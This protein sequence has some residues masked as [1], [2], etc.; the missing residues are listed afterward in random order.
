MKPILAFVLFYV[1]VA[2]GAYVF[3]RRLQYLPDT[4]LVEPWQAGLAGFERVA[5]PTADG[6]D[7]V[8]WYAPPAGGLP[9]II[10][11]QGNGLGI[12][13]RT[14]RFA[15]FHKDGYGVLALGYRGYS[16]SPGAPSE[17][18]LLA[19]AD[20]AVDF[21]EAKGFAPSRIVLY[22][23]SLGTGLAIPLAAR[24]RAGAV[25]LEAP[26]TS[27]L[28]IARRGW[29]FLPVGFLMKDQFHSLAAAGKVTVPAFVLH[30]TADEVVPFAH[31]EMIHAA[32]TGP[33]EFHPVPG[34]THGMPLTRP[35]WEAMKAF[36]RRQHGSSRI[37]AKTE[38]GA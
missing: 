7:L 28:A 36:L 25:I 17:E 19:D 20:A 2:G 16:G 10:Y 31:G 3:Q 12:A 27:A 4:R 22:G 13:Q 26:F 18:G 37:D 9:V 34:G 33:K 29:W 21:L 6:L 23:E 30:G 5:V 32:L 38:G 8:A 14:E 1:L 35:L 15:T 24:G 11:L